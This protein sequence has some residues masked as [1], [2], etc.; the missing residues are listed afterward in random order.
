[1]PLKLKELKIPIFNYKV[2][3]IS[4]NISEAVQYLE[5]AEDVLLD[6]DADCLACT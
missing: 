2:S 4:G 1:M 3:F 5:D 6:Y